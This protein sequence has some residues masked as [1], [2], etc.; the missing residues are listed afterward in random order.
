MIAE[1]AFEMLMR[2]MKAAAGG[3]GTRVHVG[4][5]KEVDEKEWTCVVERE[6]M[7]ELHDVRLNAVIDE[8]VKDRFVVVPAVGSYVLVLTMGEATEGLVVAMSKI[9][10]VM[11]Q[12]G[13]V[14]VNVSSEGVVM[15]GGELGGLID[16]AKLTDK[17]NALV[18]AFNGHTHQ[19]N[20]TGSASSQAGTASAVASKAAKLK[21]GD[22]EDVNVMH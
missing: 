3:D 12:T 9:D 10:K 20:T 13:A 1:Q 14:G 19:V 6:D 4:A 17:V 22:Y 16:I 8:G 2:A 5:V 15:N 18:E 21:R 11:I 7:P